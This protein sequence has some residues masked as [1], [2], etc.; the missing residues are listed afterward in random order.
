MPFPRTALESMTPFFAALCLS[1]ASCMPTALMPDA[2]YVGP[3][4]KAGESAGPG[5]GD[6]PGPVREARIKGPLRI[7]AGEAVLISLENNRAFKVSRLN[8]AV[9]STY[10]SQARSAFDPEA[11]GGVSWTRAVSRRQSSTGTG[12]ASSS[13]ETASGDLWGSWFLP[14]GTSLGLEF[15]TDRVNSSSY[16]D[17]LATSRLGV[18]VTQSILRGFGME[19]NLAALRQAELDTRAS[20]YELRGYAEAL[21]AEVEKAYWDYSLAESEM[22][23]FSES[24]KVAE[25][26]LRETEER[27][28]I[29]KLAETE[30]AAARAQAALRNEDMI[31]ARS[32]LAKARLRLLRLLNPPGE[33]LWDREIVLK[34][35]PAA[36]GEFEDETESRVKIA[37]RMRPEVNEARLSAQR[38]DL[39]IAKTRNGLLPRMDAFLTLG[40]SGYADSFTSSVSHIGGGTYDVSA[41]LSIE[42]PI[43]N[44][45]ARAAHDRAVA[46]R[47]QAEEALLNLEQ[48]V[49]VDV[50]TAILEVRR[51]R[52]QI[53]ATKATRSHREE[54]L[55]AEVEKFRVGKSTA[56]LVAQAERDA[57]SSRIAEVRTVVYMLKA[58][59]D[60]YRLEGSLL[61][62]RGIQAPGRE[63]AEVD[64]E[65]DE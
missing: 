61:V 55:R 33:G 21:T 38:N 43:F 41:G 16:G 50:R 40:K 25:Q 37:L 2:D 60:L 65:S 12:L 26:Q 14:T 48:I 62:R 42:Y 6:Q 30:L 51:T 10:E 39:E 28:K 57:V 49:Q 29:G 19:V 63:P 36:P 9:Y 45:S 44:R 64:R 53:A 46:R 1:L 13:S 5:A 23:I 59:V 11:G 8:P 4:R 35:K 34:E 22:E 20:R 15:E 52:E 58:L 24:L 56:F 3:A 47:A 27:V 31:N 17:P 54:A 7:S 18:S 32:S